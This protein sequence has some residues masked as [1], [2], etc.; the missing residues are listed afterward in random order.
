MWRIVMDF[1]KLEQNICEVIKEEQIKLGYRK[2][3]VR[4]FYPLLSLNRFL[5]TNIGIGE[6]LKVL[7][8]FCDIE[9]EK[10]GRIGVSNEGERFCFCLPPKASEYVHEHTGQDGFLYDFINTVSRHGVTIDEVINQFKRYSDCVHVEK[11]KH[12]EFDYLVYFEDGKP[13]SFR[14]C[15]TDEGCHVIYHRFTIDDYMD[16]NF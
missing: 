12:G 1:T 7:N 13:D 14:Y 10:L 2:E 15:L 11:V 5:K 9:E 16:F 6:M 3:T 4:L 8:E